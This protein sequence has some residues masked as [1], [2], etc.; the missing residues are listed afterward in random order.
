MAQ[1]E[2]GAELIDGLQVFFVRDNGVGF[3]LAFARDL[4]QPFRRIHEDTQFKGTG[5]GLY[6]VRRIVERHGGQVWARSQPG[7]GATF[8]FTLGIPP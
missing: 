4:F 1:I 3:A 2:F 8:Y 7:Q 5:L 6:T